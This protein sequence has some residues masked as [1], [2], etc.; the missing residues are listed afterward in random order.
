MYDEMITSP[1][2]GTIEKISINKSSRIYEWEPLFYVKTFDGGTEVIRMGITGEVQSLEVQEGDQVIPGMVL[3][4][5]KEEIID[6]SDSA[7]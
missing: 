1:C 7:S 5:I 4:Y 3:A 6:R 2:Y